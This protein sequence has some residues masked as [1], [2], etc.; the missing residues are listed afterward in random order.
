MTKKLISD[1]G[2]MKTYIEIRNI[3]S[4]EG[5]KYLRISTFF[6]GAKEPNSERTKFDMC[7]NHDTF[8][9]LKNAINEV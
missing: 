4:P 9:Y 6:D 2:G 8:Q 5:M 7:M 3:D 1:T